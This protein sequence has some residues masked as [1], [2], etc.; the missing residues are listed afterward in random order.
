MILRFIFISILFFFSG[1]STN[2]D[3]VPTESSEI[4]D[5]IENSKDDKTDEV[6]VADIDFSNWKLTLPVDE[7]NNGVI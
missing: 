3:L 2:N 7:N 4:N 6:V 5:S 1:C